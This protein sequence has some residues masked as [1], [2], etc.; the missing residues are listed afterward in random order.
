[1]NKFSVI[2]S[3]VKSVFI[4]LIGIFIGKNFFQIRPF[5]KIYNT[6]DKISDLLNYLENNYVDSVNIDSI[7]ESIINNILSGLD[8]FSN[9][10]STDE[11]VDIKESMEGDFEG[12]GIEFQILNDTITVMNSITG[13]PSEKLGILPGDKI[14]KIDSIDVGN[15]EISNSKAVS[16]LKGPK[17]TYV[18]VKINR[19]SKIYEFNIKRDKIPLTSIDFS[20]MIKSDVGIVKINRFSIKTYQEFS[21]CTKSLI[22]KGMK[23]LILDLRNNP[24]GLLS[25]A[26]EIAD[27]LLSSDKIILFTEGNSRERKVYN[28]SSNGNLHDIELHVLVNEYSAS[29]SEIIAGA[30]QDNNRG[31]V[32][33]RRTFGKGLVQEQVLM[34][35]GSVVRLTTSRYFTPSGRCIQIPY[36]SENSENSMDNILVR[37]NNGE[38]FSKDSI[39]IDTSKK[40]L[41]TDGKVVYGGGGIIPD[42][43]IPIDNDNKYNNNGLLNIISFNLISKFIYQKINVN[44]KNINKYN[45]LDDFKYNYSISDSLFDSFI[46]FCENDL[47]EEIKINNVEDRNLLKLNLKATIARKKFKN[48]GY[49]AI[50]NIRDDA[51]N[52]SLKLFEQ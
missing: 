8:P 7:R 40:F 23:K 11:F 12:I 4:L 47:N 14:I 43:F 48:E 36:N 26:I 5:L 50:L 18:S 6:P 41:T 29:A 21:V 3:L 2:N 16:L 30:I 46:N 20:Y 10:I 49:Y 44:S 9:Y 31:I 17:D 39:K 52:E 22:D 35:D 33:G 24:G 13:G 1:M 28:S 51:I 15:I 37:F 45:S 38:F 34:D 32:I 25:S 42:V 19:N 27:E